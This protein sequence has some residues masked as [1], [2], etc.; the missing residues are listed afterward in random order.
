MS[1][2]QPDYVPGYQPGGSAIPIASLVLPAAPAALV[3]P[4]IPVFGF[5]ALYLQVTQSVANPVQYTVT[6]YADAAAT[7]QVGQQIIF[8]KNSLVQTEMV[9][10]VLG[11]YV[12]IGAT[13][14]A[15]PSITVSF[16]AAGYVQNIADTVKRVRLI[17][18][19]V[20]QQG[21][22]LGVSATV[23]VL[24]TDPV[25]GNA[26]AIPGN[27]HYYCVAGQNGGLKIQ[28]WTG[29]AWDDVALFPFNG[30]VPITGSWVLPQ[31]DYRFLVI[32][33]TAT[34]TT[35]TL[36]VTLDP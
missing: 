31:S 36:A 6:Y 30:L 28:Q 15:G 25:T 16:V 5:G 12:R 9:G 4:P 23:T 1:F 27:V 33:N 20:D 7:V 22:V 21:A 26:D 17:D 8:R 2:D 29:A 13:T 11:P 10:T 32:N 24:P 14:T 19:I 3:T 35:F 18:L 34:A